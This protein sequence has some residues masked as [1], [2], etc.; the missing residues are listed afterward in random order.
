MSY[1]MHCDN[2][3]RLRKSREVSLVT[4]NTTL[5]ISVYRHLSLS[6]P[7]LPHLYVCVCLT[8]IN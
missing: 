3:K 4:I 2:L 6:L 8:K 7:P 5:H 1:E